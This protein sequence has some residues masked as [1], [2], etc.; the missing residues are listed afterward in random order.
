MA[1]RGR[2]LSHP[3]RRPQLGPAGS[4]ESFLFD[5][6]SWSFWREL[7]G[8]QLG[9]LELEVE[10]H[11]LAGEC[12]DIRIAFVI[13]RLVDKVAADFFAVR[14]REAW[15]RSSLVIADF[16]EG[17]SHRAGVDVQAQSIA[18]KGNDGRLQPAAL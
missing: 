17:R 16:D 5:W 4:R 11:W 18:G 9:A 2:S 13:H 6:A 12:R 1:R 14:Q 8:V 10:F 3:S 7:E 15:N